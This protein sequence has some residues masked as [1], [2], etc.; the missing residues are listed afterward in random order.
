M[1]VG[2]KKFEDI[3]VWQKAIQ[4]YYKINLICEGNSLKRDFSAK[5]Q[6]SRATLSISN[7]I[8]EGFEYDNTGDLIRF[9]KYAKGSSGEVRSML[10]AFELSGKINKEEASVLKAEL[11]EISK[12]LKGFIS[13]L[14]EYKQTK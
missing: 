10:C 14:T 8:A 5:D 3:E 7:N 1:K 13:C 11:E 9:L 6:I 12:N 4:L 2:I